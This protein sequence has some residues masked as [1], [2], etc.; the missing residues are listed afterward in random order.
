V[1]DQANLRLAK[2]KPDLL[3]AKTAIG[4]EINMPRTNKKLDYLSEKFSELAQV[5]MRATVHSSTRFKRR[6][7]IL[8]AQ[9]TDA[10]HGTPPKT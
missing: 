1:I 6:Q 5:R 9:T 4:C 3:I 10:M 7:T 2:N 8:A